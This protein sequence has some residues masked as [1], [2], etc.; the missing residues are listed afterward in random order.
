MVLPDLLMVLPGLAE[1]LVDFLVLRGFWGGF[2]LVLTPLVDGG[3]ATAKS[4]KR[5]T[6]SMAM[7]LSGSFIP[8]ARRSPP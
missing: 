8:I 5:F 6:L 3:P 7:M 4:T 1:R 2:E